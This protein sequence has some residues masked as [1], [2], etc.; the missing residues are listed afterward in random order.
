MFNKLRP[1]Q[2]VDSIYD[3]DYLKL[4]EHGI[5]GVIADLDNTLIPWDTDEISQDLL[6]WVDALKSAGLKLAILSNS[7]SLSRVENM[8][9]KLDIFAASKAI[10]PR[11]GGFRNIAAHFGLSPNQM[12]VIGDQ[13]FTDI[14]GGN[15]AGMH[16]ILVLPLSKA[17]FIGTKLMR[18]LER[19]FLSRLKI[20][21]KKT[22]T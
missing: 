20:D 1:D 13:L 21:R 3:I 7:F 12:A 9:A 10:K 6:N 16:T 4:A 8:S 15:R 2:M 11:R 22:G 14:L 17:E 5:K 18:L 19:F